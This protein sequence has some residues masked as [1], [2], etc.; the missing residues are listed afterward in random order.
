MKRLVGLMVVAVLSFGTPPH[1]SASAPTRENVP[2]ETG[3]L[4]G[5]FCGFDVLVEPQKNKAKMTVFYDRNG[6]M[7][8]GL[9]TGV[10]KVRL[11][12]LTTNRS[13]ELNISSSARL[14]PQQNGSLLATVT[15]PS[16]FL[17]APGSKVPGLPTLAVFHGRVVVELDQSA[18][19]R[20][21]TYRGSPPQDVC[22]MLA[23]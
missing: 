5:M 8:V 15:G 1:A 22:A 23:G 4:P 7:R 2:F 12:N 20:V 17:L 14:E 3:V 16:L 6:N 18:D 21:Q 19:W 10:L 11:T 13:V 9:V